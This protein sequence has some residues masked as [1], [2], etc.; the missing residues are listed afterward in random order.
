[1]DA[2]VFESA[3]VQSPPGSHHRPGAHHR[4][5]NRVLSFPQHTGGNAEKES[6]VAFR[7]T[8]ELS[9]GS[10]S[11]RRPFLGAP[12]RLSSDRT[13]GSV[14]STLEEKDSYDVGGAKS[15]GHGGAE[16]SCQKHGEIRTP[17]LLLR[18]LSQQLRSSQN[19][20][21]IF[22]LVWRCA[23]L[24]ASTEHILNTIS[25]RDSQGFCGGN[26][27]ASSWS[28]YGASR[29]V[30]SRLMPRTVRDSFRCQVRLL[31]VGCHTR[32]R[33]PAL[34]KEEGRAVNL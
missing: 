25:P 24:S 4:D 23:A 32:E 11:G 20:L 15:D 22:A 30:A 27:R 1:M 21:L 14:I 9:R 16:S 2:G 12:A 33:S 7:A 31:R 3:P 13:G 29:S 18:R 6:L 28:G 26:S 10:D 5:R 8:T 34:G 17:D 19:Q